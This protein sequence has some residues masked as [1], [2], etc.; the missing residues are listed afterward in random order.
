[1]SDQKMLVIESFLRVRQHDKNSKG[2]KKGRRFIRRGKE[3]KGLPILGHPRTGEGAEQKKKGGM[4][5]RRKQSEG[6]PFETTCFYP[7]VEKKG[8]ANGG[9]GGRVR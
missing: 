6:E 4:A 9:G 1:M 3:R 2:R 7:V 5:D 8:G